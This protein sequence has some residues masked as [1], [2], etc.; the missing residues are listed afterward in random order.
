LNQLHLVLAAGVY[1]LL[2]NSYRD[3]GVSPKKKPHA[4]NES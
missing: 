3:P 4:G 2:Y 1:C